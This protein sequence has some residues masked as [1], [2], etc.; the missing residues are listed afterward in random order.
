MPF[1]VRPFV[2]RFFA[3]MNS[4][5]SKKGL[6]EQPVSDSSVSSER[7]KTGRVFA[8]LGIIC[9][10]IAFVYFPVYFAPIGCVLGIVAIRK[11]ARQL[12]WNAV[13][14]SIGGLIVGFLLTFLLLSR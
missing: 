9:G 10:G 4:F 14:V 1:Q 8:L 3:C 7:L 13:G 6:S 11:G 2:S 5:E 12:G